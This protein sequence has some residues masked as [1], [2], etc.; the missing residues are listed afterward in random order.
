MENLWKNNKDGSFT[1][2]RNGNE[3]GVYNDSNS[4]KSCTAIITLKNSQYKINRK[5]F[6]KTDILL[7]DEAGKEV[8][9]VKSLNWY[10]RSYTL[11]FDNETF[12]LKI[13]NN[14]LS[15]WS[16]YKNDILQLTYSLKSLNGKSGLE[17]REDFD[18]PVWF[19]YLLWYLIKPVIVENTGSDDEL[20]LLLVAAAS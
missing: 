17:I 2:I 10:G 6:W 1:L 14:P 12:T 20:M 15:E 16:L 13:G 8:L 5:G 4:G 9:W 19:H 18:N 7:C 3:A 11:T